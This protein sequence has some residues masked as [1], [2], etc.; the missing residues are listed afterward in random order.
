M[1][2]A[3]PVRIPLHLNYALL[4]EALKQ[5][6][7]I[8]DGRAELWNGSNN[9]EYLY[10]ENPSFIQ[11]NGILR[12]VTA[13]HLNIGVPVND[14]CLSPIT[15]SGI[16]EADTEPYI[17]GFAL[18]LHVTDINL[19]DHHH[20]KSLP[21]GRGFDLIKS[22][23][24]PALET[25]SF[26]LTPA[27]HELEGLAKMAV[28]PADEASMRSALATIRLEPLVA[29]GQTGLQLMLVIDLPL[30]SESPPA[31]SAA[32]LTLDEI[33]AWNRVLNNWDAFLVFTV[34]QIGATVADPSVRDQ[35][36]NILLDSR[37]RLV[38][39][40]GQ[41]QRVSGPDPIRL[42]FLEE[43]T[44]LG[45][46]IEDAARLGRLGNRTLEFLSFITA[47]DALFAFDQ[48][49][50]ALGIRISADDLRRLARLMAPRAS[51]DPL[52]YSFDEDPEL[53]R[54]FGLGAPLELPG[55][56]ERPSESEPAEAPGANGEFAPGNASHAA[57]GGTSSRVSW[58]K[59]QA[60]AD[61]WPAVR[62]T[63]PF[64]V[65]GPLSMLLSGVCPIASRD[66]FAGEIA[67]VTQGSFHQILALGRKLQAVVV[68]ARNALAYRHDMNQLLDLAARYQIQSAVIDTPSRR[69]WPSLVKAT[70]WQ[71]SCWRQ[72]VIRHRRIWYLESKSGDIGL[73]QVNKFVWRGF[74]SLARLRWDIVYNLGAGSEIMRRSLALSPS[75]LDFDPVAR[76]RSAYAAYNG[77]PDAYDRWRQPNE[78]RSWR[79]I[80]EA[81]LLKYQAIEAGE[82]FDILSCA[83]SWDSAHGN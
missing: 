35:L 44:R 11:Q 27:I 20:E 5:K 55:D 80:D 25:Y 76:A 40:L 43:W 32:P 24:I 2:L 78:R 65:A 49:A 28:T 83:A 9:C 79:D 39:A 62:S 19:Y 54:M 18:R 7:Y 81:F 45:H 38:V 53:R 66:A 60:S 33:A 23:L 14:R 48:A 56:L 15:W 58:S 71:E 10:A 82:F 51:G 72:Y 73:M 74:Y 69:S 57:S 17:A 36:L 8:N 68:S 22:N 75:H 34:K 1:L 30:A 63:A 31:P 77:G 3:T 37:E 52:A 41:P 12:I 70:A 6:L 42:L 47:G 21:V 59:L 4:T 13:G 64:Y 61:G 26:D 67:T 46:V 16:I 29:K 50:P